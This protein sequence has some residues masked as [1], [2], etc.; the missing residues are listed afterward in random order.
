MARESTPMSMRFVSLLTPSSK[1]NISLSIADT[2]FAKISA[3]GTSYLRTPAPRAAAAS[4]PAIS[5]S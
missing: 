1:S 2:L 5:P 4:P 3:L